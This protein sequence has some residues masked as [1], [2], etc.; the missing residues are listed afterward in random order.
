MCVK[1]IHKKKKKKS[2]WK[3]QF[4]LIIFNNITYKYYFVTKMCNIKIINTIVYNLY[5]SNFQ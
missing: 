1:Q 5:N 3:C 4:E 2:K